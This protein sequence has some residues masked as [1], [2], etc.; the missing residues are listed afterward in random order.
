MLKRAL[1]L[2]LV[3]APFLVATSAQAADICEHITDPVAKVTCW[4]NGPGVAQPMGPGSGGTGGKDEEEKKV[5][6]PTE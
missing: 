5:S 4:L 3:T 2:A 6:Q 1:T